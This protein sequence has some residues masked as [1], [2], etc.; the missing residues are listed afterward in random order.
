MK[1]MGKQCA[2][3]RYLRVLG[4]RDC[5]NSGVI[6]YEEIK[7]QMLGGYN[8]QLKVPNVKPCLLSE[9]HISA[10]TQ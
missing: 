9:E 10:H 7:Y 3:E 4:H 6:S 8:T 1:R 5:W 2:W